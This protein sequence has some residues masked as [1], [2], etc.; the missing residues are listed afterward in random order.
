LADFP[1]QPRWRSFSFVIDGH[2]YVGGGSQDGALGSDYTDCYRFNPADGSW[3]PIA[4]FPEGWGVAGYAAAIDGKG[5]VG[6]GVNDE[7]FGNVSTRLWEYDPGADAWTH[8]SNTPGYQIGRMYAFSSVHDGKLYVGGGRVNTWAAVLS[9]MYGDFYVWDKGLDPAPEDYDQ[10]ESLGRGDAVDEELV[11]VYGIRA[12]SEDTL[13]ALPAPN[14]TF[15]STPLQLMYSA[16]GGATWETFTVD[17][18][19]AYYSAHF[20]ALDSRRAWVMGT[21]LGGFTNVFRTQDGGQTWEKILDSADNLMP[22]SNGI[23]F[24]DDEVG[25]CWGNDFYDDPR[26]YF[27]RTE[28]GGATWQQLDDPALP[29]AFSFEWAFSNTGNNNY[30]AMGD[31]IWIPVDFIMVRSTD[32]GATWARV[33]FDMS[34]YSVAF[35]DALRG[36]TISDNWPGVTAARAFVTEDG[37]ATWTEVSQP[38]PAVISVNHIPGSPGAYVAYS[39][40]QCDP[41]LAYTPNYGQDWVNIYA[42][43]ALHA[44]HFLSPELAYAG[45]PLRRDVP[46]GVYR[47]K[48]DLSV[49]N[50]LYVKADATGANTGRTWHD[51]FTDLQDALA[52]AQ[53]G[54]EIWVAQG[55]YTPAAPG[56]DRNATFRV[57]KDLHLYGGFAGTEV[58]LEERGDPAGHPAIL[59][60]DLNGDD[61]AG[62]FEA[63][64]SDN[65]YTVVSVALG[66]TGATLIDGFTIRGGHADGPGSGPD[67]N[68]GGLRTQGRPVVQ[69]CIFEYNYAQQ[70]G[71]GMVYANANAGGEIRGCVFRHNRANNGGGF[72][73]Y[74]ADYLIEGCTFE[75]NATFESTLP[76]NG[77]GIY[78]ENGNGSVRDCNF[79][80]N[81]A[82]ANGGGLFAW[83][84]AATAGLTLDI[85]GCTF[86]GNTAASTGGGMTLNPWGDDVVYT[87]TDC[88]FDGNEA[89]ATSGGGLTLNVNANAANHQFSLTHSD[90]TRNVGSAAFVVTRGQNTGVEISNCSFVENQDGEYSPI[91]N[92]WSTANATSTV[93]IDSCHFENNVS[94]YSGAIEAGA[95]YN[96]TPSLNLTL[97]NSSFIGNASMESGAVTIWDA[98]GATTIALV[99]NCLFDNNSA[100]FS[101]G[102]M[103]T[104]PHDTKFRADIKRCIFTNNESPDG[105]AIKSFLFFPGPDFPENARLHIENSLF[106][107]NSGSSATISAETMPN[108]SLLNCTIADND[109]GGV[110]ISSQSGLRLQNTILYNPGNVE[111]AS[112]GP[113]NTF[114]SAGGN[115]IGDLSLDGRLVPGD[116]Q[117]LDPLFANDGSYQLTPESPCVDAGVNEG[118]TAEFDLAG[119]PRIQGLRVDMGAYE[120]PFV[121]SLKETSVYGEASVWPNP[122]RDFLFVQ[123][124][125]SGTAPFLLQLLDAQGRVLGQHTIREGAPLDVALLPAGLYSLKAVVDGK[126]FTGKFVKQ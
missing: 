52:I 69:H 44:I 119:N 59:S 112:G 8:V 86:Q 28:D 120:S 1:G 84:T 23:H 12:I 93:A 104:F 78:L 116:K 7:Y 123:L 45:G 19:R 47:W 20:H 58:R 70:T 26:A 105:G 3:T 72:G 87:V 102:A 24:F 30:A 67:I 49:F 27:Y 50:R 122:A 73:S 103:V 61:V 11:G 32:R 29:G 107:G 63:N 25:L 4:D 77:G 71:G 31:T 62:D 88:R 81:S 121:S 57:D 13:W 85:S 60:G 76:P 42:P 39:T 6:E 41:H 90:F 108:L 101:G 38:S 51:A 95:G 117:D 46:E 68:G 9:P 2:A 40:I 56:G 43:P 109:D 113:E 74:S 5:Y 18:Q 79:V 75:G 126:V 53:P 64:R 48:G 99:E 124:P 17:D 15:S 66:I 98:V 80:S 37:G 118:V 97:A 94:L 35:E 82:E 111:Y 114:T 100:T 115:L 21:L 54:E 83:C 33:D 16:D 96:G 34:I 91:L 89:P 65:V 22:E 10:W 125:E 92:I 14:L 110:E 55:L 36:M 106:A